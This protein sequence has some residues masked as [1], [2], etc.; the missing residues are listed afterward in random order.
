MTIDERLAYLAEQ[1]QALAESV[2]LL[3]EDIHAMQRK[4]DE[5][6]QRERQARAAIIAGIVAYLKALQ[7]GA[8]STE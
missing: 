1:H 2:Q 8:E 4:H 6:D 5:L 7:D 3:T